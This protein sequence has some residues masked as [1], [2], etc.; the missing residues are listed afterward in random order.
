[1]IGAF[2]A[3]LK[4][5]GLLLLV[6]LGILFILTTLVLFWPVKYKAKIKYALKELE[7]EIEVSWLARFILFYI[8]KDGNAEKTLFRIAWFKIANKEESNENN[9]AENK[10]SENKKP[11]EAE[12]LNPEKECKE[13]GKTDEKSELS[14]AETD[15]ETDDTNKHTADFQKEEDDG[16]KKNSIASVFSKIKEIYNYPNKDEIIKETII[17]LK[18]LLKALKPKYFNLNCEF[19]FETPDMTGMAL[20]IAGIVRAIVYKDNFNIEF[21]GNFNEKT[22]NLNTGLGGKIS[23]WSSLWSL[24]AFVFKKPIWKIIR[25][26]LFNKKNSERNE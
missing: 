16:K 20:G 19:G 14:K 7:Y 26:K 12:K 24:I 1:M 3:I 15:K 6:I 17:L 18:R 22:L 5:I 23:L 13:S 10:K 8:M 2:F 25:P 4:T 21:R 9:F 11:V